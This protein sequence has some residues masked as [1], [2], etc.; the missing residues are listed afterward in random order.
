MSVENAEHLDPR[1][2]ARAVSTGEP[3]PRQTADGHPRFDM[4][5][6]PGGYAWWY[7]DG[8]SD[9]GRHAITLIAFVGS[10]FSPYYYVTGRHRPESHCALNVALY[11]PGSRWAMTERPGASVRRDAARFDIGPSSVRWER[12]RMVIDVN[13]TGFPSL[14]PIRG[15]VTVHPTALGRRVVPLDAAGD[16]AWWAIAPV[17]RIEVELERPALRWSGHGYI[18]MNHGTAMLEQGFRRWDWS[19]FVLPD[20]AAVLYEAERQDGSTVSLGLRFDKDGRDETFEPPPSKRM[21]RTLWWLRRHTRAED[22]FTPKELIRCEDSPFYSRSVIRS[23]VLGQDVVGMH[24]S[25]DL[26]RFSSPFV[27]MLLPCRMPRALW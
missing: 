3:I 21:S 5:V 17:A 6:P 26:R 13:E 9:D 24:E 1:P 27:K 16:Q 23:R 4:T 8:L 10:V 19:R 22:G 14:L 18:D 25:L 12:D 7:V 20:G 2:M 11:G 15:R